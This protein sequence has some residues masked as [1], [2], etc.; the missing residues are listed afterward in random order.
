MLLYRLVETRIGSSG[1]S[2]SR[3][4]FE[5]TIS[6]DKD[7]IW[8]QVWDSVSEALEQLEF[9]FIT[10]HIF[11]EYLKAACFANGGVVINGSPDRA[12]G[13][14]YSFVISSFDSSVKTVFSL[15]HFEGRYV[16]DL[17]GFLMDEPESALR[18]YGVEMTEQNLRILNNIRKEKDL[19][20][21]YKNDYLTNMLDER[22]IGDM[23]TEHTKALREASKRGEDVNTYEMYFGSY[24][25]DLYIEQS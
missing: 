1:G 6:P 4:N 25:E 10:L 9:P 5:V 18:E 20:N 24:I 2:G 17:I 12:D 3:D 7:E 21:E 13:Y 15:E 16:E 8:N 14:Y 22:T 19:R 23:R 11:E